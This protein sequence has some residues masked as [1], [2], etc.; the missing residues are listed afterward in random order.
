MDKYDLYNDIAVRTDGDI[1]IGVV[2]PVRTGKSTFIKRFMDV[3]VLPNI[4]NAYKKE[5]TIDELPQS[6]AGKTI[7]TTQPKFVPNEAVTIELRNSA[8]LSLRMVDCVGYLIDGVIGHMENDVP[9]M[10]RTP[11]NDSDIPFEEAA[12]IGTRKV[13]TEHSTIGILVTTDGSFTGIPHMDYAPAEERVVKELKDINKPFIVLLNT[14]NPN[15]EE[16]QQL[17]KSLEEKYDVTVIASNVTK[18]EL[19]DVHYLLERV[20]FEFPLSEM[21]FNLPRWVQA[22]PADHWLVNEILTTLSDST[23]DLFRMRDVEKLLDVFDESEYVNS[24]DI[25]NISLSDGIL[26]YDIDVKHDLFYQILGEECGCEINDDYQLVSMMKS[27]VFAKKEYDRVSEALEAVRTTGYGLVSPTM[28][29]MTLEEPEIVKQGGRYG[30]R[31]RASAPSLHMI[32]VDIQTEVSPVVGTEKQSEEI[33][34]YLLSEFESDPSSIWES[35]IFG[36]SLHELV[37]EGLSTKLLRM[38]EDAQHKMQDTL[39]RIIN[40]GSGG[41]ICILL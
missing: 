25:D 18:L 12:E 6:G 31:L 30:V 38:P 16:T 37:K 8:A 24:I 10:V 2:G 19:E 4:D 20:L 27:L 15:S 34:R 28:D 21:R 9:R 41:L 35:N 11:W 36:K 22:L 14:M 13:I 3:M 39:S 1:Y 5:R 26:N 32:R 23:K 7:M 40:E 17:R 29:E 33:L